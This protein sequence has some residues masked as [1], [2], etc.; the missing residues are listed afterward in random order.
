[1]KSHGLKSCWNHDNIVRNDGRMQGDRGGGIGSVVVDAVR[2]T[3]SCR[4]SVLF[5]RPKV[6]R[7]IPNYHEK[8]TTS[9]T[10]EGWGL[11]GEDLTFAQVLSINTNQLASLIAANGE[12]QMY[13]YQRILNS[14]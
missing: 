14:A 3:C 13:K 5:P 7:S 2:T 9:V 4:D 6:E 10:V 1:A 12:R 8:F 11:V